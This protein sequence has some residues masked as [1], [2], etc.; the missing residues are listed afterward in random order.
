MCITDIRMN[1]LD[2][3]TKFN[4]HG[5]RRMNLL[6]QIIQHPNT[7]TALHQGSAQMATNKPGAA[8]HQD[9]IGHPCLLPALG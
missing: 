1:E 6:D 5:A 7:V 2:I 4:G 9:G 3:I 8:G